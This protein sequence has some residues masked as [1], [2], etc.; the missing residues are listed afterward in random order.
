MSNKNKIFIAKSYY[1]IQ[2]QCKHYARSAYSAGEAKHYG[3][4]KGIKS[5]KS[6]KGVSGNIRSKK[7][8]KKLRSLR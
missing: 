7:S 4:I 3:S 8:L 5:I 6:L 2:F 1:T